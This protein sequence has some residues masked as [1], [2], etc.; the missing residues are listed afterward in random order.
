[1]SSP[2]VPRSGATISLGLV[3]DQFDGPCAVVADVLARRCSY[4]CGRSK[5]TASPFLHW[6]FPLSGE[7]RRISSHRAPILGRVSPFRQTVLSAGV[8]RVRVEISHK[9]S[10]GGLGVAL[11]RV[12]QRHHSRGPGARLPSQL[13]SPPSPG[14]PASGGVGEPTRSLRPNSVT[15]PRVRGQTAELPPRA[16]GAEDPRRWPFLRLGLPEEAA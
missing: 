6:P 10:L 5:G 8:Q 13:C 16:I 7:P 4:R 12:R 15:R 14:P 3:K 2:T 1:M 9:S 11:A